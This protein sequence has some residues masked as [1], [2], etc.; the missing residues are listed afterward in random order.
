MEGVIEGIKKARI[1]V[2]ASMQNALEDGFAKWQVSH[3]EGMRIYGLLQKRLDANIEK[4]IQ[5]AKEDIKNILKL[6]QPSTKKITLYRNIRP[7]NILEQYSIGQILEFKSFVSTS[8]NPSGTSYSKDKTFARYEITVPKGTPII[9]ASNY[10]EE[11]NEKDEIILHPI[12][13]KITNVKKSNIENCPIIVELEFVNL[14][15]VGF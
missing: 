12:K 10:P 7:N 13:C 9:I 1:D 3:S 11:M 4:N 14:I 8:I 6:M 2:K 15:E 5:Q